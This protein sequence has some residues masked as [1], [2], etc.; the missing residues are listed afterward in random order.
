M[1]DQIC[2]IG[3]GISG[4]AAG[5]ALNEVGLPYVCF[6]A[7][8]K[9]GGLWWLENDNGM[10]NI[11]ESLRTN[12]SSPRTGFSD[13]PMP[14]S[15]PDFPHHSQVQQYLEQYVRHFGLGEAIQT[16]HRV[17]HVEAAEDGGYNVTVCGPDGESRTDRFR[18]VLV[19]N[20]HHWDPHVPDLPGEFDGSVIHSSQYKSARPFAGKRV[21]IVG[22]GNSA[23]DMA[24]DLCENAIVTMSTRS[25]AHIVPRHLLGQPIDS[26]T[27]DAASRLPITVQRTLFSLLVWIARGRQS[28][29]GFPEPSAPFLS[30]H[31]TISD[32]LLDRVKEGAV[33]VERGISSVDGNRV[34]FEDGQSGSFDTIILAT[35]Y[36]VTFPFFDPDFIAAPGNEIALYNHV[37]DPDHEDLYF[38]GLIQP[39]GALAPLA[40]AQARW[41][42]ALLAGTASLPGRDDMRRTISRDNAVR[43]KLFVKTRRHTLEVEFFGYLRRLK[44]ARGSRSK[45]L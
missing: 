40:E 45:A 2:V 31:P 33:T 25:G 7:G 15:Y 17:E 19:C 5:R 24:V 6:E 1:S 38:I 30:A 8:S 20:G 18:S 37:V 10:S 4:I 26:W 36:S 9:P 3:A 32:Y 22:A 27:S 16:R 34:N 14:E 43:D 29:Y 13:L 41:V 23:C 44:R 11:Y 12:T 21:L 28:R 39:L 42:A 35:G